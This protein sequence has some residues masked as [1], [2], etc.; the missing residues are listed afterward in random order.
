M[1]KSHADSVG[2]RSQPAQGRP[3]RLGQNRMRAF[4]MVRIIRL[5]VSAAAA[6]ADLL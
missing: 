2:E 5:M 6:D 4:E 3:H 1:P